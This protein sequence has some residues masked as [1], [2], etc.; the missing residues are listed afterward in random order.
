[1]PQAPLDDLLAHRARFVSFV[2]SRI[3]D[4]EA[5]EDIVQEALAQVVAQ[6]RHIAGQDLMRWFYRVLRNAM[7]DRHRRRTA[8]AR[9][10][11]RWKVDPTTHPDAGS[12]RRACGCVRSALD[13]LPAKSRAILE[14]VELRGMTPSAY[15]RAHD[16]SSGNAAVRLHRARRLLADRLKG[17]CGTCTLDGCSDCDCGHRAAPDL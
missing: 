7:I 6:P 11:E 10:L 12:P 15:G 5:A 2:R 4:R 16:I 1:M 14:A 17:I 8:E 9:A 3:G 13:G